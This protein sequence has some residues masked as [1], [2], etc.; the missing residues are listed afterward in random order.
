MTLDMEILDRLAPT[1]GWE[2]DWA[3][4]LD[5]AGEQRERRS[6]RLAP[7]QRRRGR[8][9][10]LVGLLAAGVIVIATPALGVIGAI[11]DLFEGT[12][13]TPLV[14]QHFMTWNGMQR[15]AKHPPHWNQFNVNASKAHGVL[16]MRTNDGPVYLW[17]APTRSGGTC[18]LLQFVNHKSTPTEPI[19]PSGCLGT[20]PTGSSV[21][22]WGILPSPSVW[23]SGAGTGPNSFGILIGEAFGDASYVIVESSRRPMLRV[24]I[25]EHFFAA[26]VP[27]GA[28]IQKITS[29]DSHGKQLAESAH[30][31]F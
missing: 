17:V 29:Y 16:A 9:L 18:W 5:R 22:W 3:D 25:V 1:S 30:Q 11:R 4:V 10:L 6:P 7:P 27:G 24:P 21:G 31:N 19:G 28:A 15:R 8:L 12:P 2:A 20:T 26:V 14:Q 13:P 23:R